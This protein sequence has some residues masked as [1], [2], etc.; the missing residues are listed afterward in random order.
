LS[1]QQASPSSSAL[2]SVSGSAPLPSCGAFL[3]PRVEA[4]FA[5]PSRRWAERRFTDIRYWNEPERGGHF[6]AFEQPALFVKE[7][8]ECFRALR[9]PRL[10]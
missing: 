6:A 4:G 1:G 5:E 3:R 7:V 10:G 8:R 2:L 9:M